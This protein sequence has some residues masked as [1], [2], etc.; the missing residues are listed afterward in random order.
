MRAEPCQAVRCP[1]LVT[2]FHGRC[3]DGITVLPRQATWREQVTSPGVWAYGFVSRS[4]RADFSCVRRETPFNLI[5]EAGGL[6]HNCY[7]SLSP[8]LCGVEGLPVRDTVRGADY[9]S[10]FT[11]DVDDAVG[12]LFLVTGTA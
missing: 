5:R 11:A 2:P 1:F 8:V 6:E 7:G 10:L 3:C 12:T 4:A 9:A